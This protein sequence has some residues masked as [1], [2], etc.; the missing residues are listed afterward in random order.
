[1]EAE[2]ANVAQTMAQW[3]DLVQ[4]AGILRVPQHERSFLIILAPDSFSRI[5]LLRQVWVVT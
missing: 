1:M 4:A 5:T 2:L 3:L